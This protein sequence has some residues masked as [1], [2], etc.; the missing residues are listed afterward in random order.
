MKAEKLLTVQIVP[1]QPGWE[2]LSAVRGD[3][4]SDGIKE[5]SPDPIIAWVIRVYRDE[6]EDSSYDS[7][8]CLEPVTIEGIVPVTDLIYRR[9]DGRIVLTHDRTI[10]DEADA[11]ALFKQ[12]SQ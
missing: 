3:L 8:G 9:P 12:R 4:H 1:A 7:L 10:T 11:L 6:A 2:I 5:F